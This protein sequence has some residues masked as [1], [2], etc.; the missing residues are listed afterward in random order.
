[1]STGKA[2]WKPGRHSTNEHHFSHSTI[3]GKRAEHPSLVAFSRIGRA[4][5]CGREAWAYDRPSCSSTGVTSPKRRP[6]TQPSPVPATISLCGM[7]RFVGSWFPRTDTYEHAR[8]LQGLDMR[9]IDTGPMSAGS[10]MMR[11]MCTILAPRHTNRFT[12]KPAARVIK[13]VNANLPITRS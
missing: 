9:K 10:S 2:T 7:D 1:M 12:L 5:G 6:R 13:T 3:R 4:C 11:Y 8:R